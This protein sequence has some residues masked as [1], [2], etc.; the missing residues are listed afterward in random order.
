MIEFNADQYRAAENL[1]MAY[2]AWA[3]NERVWR[4]HHDR[5]DWVT[6][7]GNEYLYRIIDRDGNATSLGPRSEELERFKAEY[8]E[9]RGQAKAARATLKE[10]VQVSSRIARATRL[11]GLDETAGKILVEADL[12]G[13]LGT[14]VI[15]VGTN[16]AICYAYAA[17]TTL[18]PD[19][20]AT[21]DFD[22]AWSGTKE[23]LAVVDLS[24]RPILNLLKSVDSTFTVNTERP[25]QARN[26]HA[27]E[28]E[29]LAAPSVKHTIPGA[30]GLKPVGEMIEQEWLLLGKTVR[31]IVRT[32]GAWACPI[33]APDPRWF[34]LHK[35]WLS[36]KPERNP[37]KIR[38]DGEQGRL[39]WKMSKDGL[40]PF[41]RIDRKFL[42]TIP[43][44]LAE[45]AHS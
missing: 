3:D 20:Q 34:A 40:F 10:A 44:E 23:T 7:K 21:K 24:D 12:R 4:E 39:I 30:D 25:F 15:T 18:P 27:Y 42:D 43:Q 35:S 14:A 33:V 8:D 28:V 22:L 17:G 6:R 41:H 29:L 13:L 31:Q 45:F 5:L 36:R 32:D 11:P 26:R 9:T 19:L 38:K 16:A 2:D 1:A 37:N